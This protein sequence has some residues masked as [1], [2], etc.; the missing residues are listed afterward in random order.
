MANKSKKLNG[1]AYAKI[2][3]SLDV[4]KKRIDGYHEVDLIMHTLKNLYDEIEIISKKSINNKLAINV[5]SNK[6]IPI[7]MKKNLA[8]KA[9]EA[10]CKKY[11]INDNITIK[12]K[13]N[14]P[15]SSGMGG[16]SSDAATTIKLLN[17]IYNLK[18]SNKKMCEISKPLGADV[19]HFI[20]GGSNRAR[21]IG[22]DL[23]M[24]NKFKMHTI[25]LAKP[26][27]NKKTGNIYK[28]IDKYPKIFR[29]IKI[30]RIVSY[31]NKNDIKKA[32]ALFGNILEASYKNKK[33]SYIKNIMN[34]KNC[35]CALMSGAGPTVFGLFKNK[36]D[37]LVCAKILRRGDKKLWVS[38]V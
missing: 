22:Q 27:I 36:K 26:D 12:I 28:K 20:I 38:I 1:K 4:L 9:C 32:C 33:F 23:K 16:G 3:L 25:L 31:L 5:I 2:N 17:K 13:K 10:I 30:S 34:S 18:L 11:N 21:G 14:I 6:K 29:K 35:L 19:P 37:A 24:I 7:S 8:Y 15:L